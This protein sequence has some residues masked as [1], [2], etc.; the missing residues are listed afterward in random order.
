MEHGN[1]YQIKLMYEHNLQRTAC[2]MTYGPFGGVK[3]KL[4]VA[5]SLLLFNCE[6]VRFNLD[7]ERQHDAAA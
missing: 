2:N 3:G 4:F 7:F 1:Q 6:Q 5:Y